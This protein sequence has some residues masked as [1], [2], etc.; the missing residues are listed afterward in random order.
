MDKCSHVITI[1]SNFCVN[2]LSAGAIV[3]YHS[4]KSFGTFSK[5]PGLPGGADH[6]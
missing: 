5:K 3:M 1:A 2:V 4:I 6:E